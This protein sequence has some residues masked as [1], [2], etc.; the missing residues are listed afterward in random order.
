M[1]GFIMSD[2]IAKL[3]IIACFIAAVYPRNALSQDRVLTLRAALNYS[4]EGNP[5]IRVAWKGLLVQKE[6]IGIATGNLLP[7]VVFEERFMRTDNPT[8]AFMA[9]LNQGRFTAQDFDIPSL[10]NPA[11]ISDFQ[12]A[13][14]IEQP[15]FA[16]KAAI[17]ID[18]AR[19]EFEAKNEE[20]DRKREEV[21]FGVIKGYLGI[22]TAKAY[23]AVAEKGIDDAR[24]H[25]R[26][27]D[28]RYKENLGLYS[29]SLR[30]KAALSSAEERLVTA[31]KN[32]AVA[33]RGL[34]LM[35]GLN[36]SVDV[37]EERPLLELKPLEYYLNLTLSRKDLRSL[38]T[39]YK[40]AENMLKMANA[41]YY[42]T[43]GVGG[44]YQMND[45]AKPFGSEGQ[46]WQVAAFLRWEIF[47]GTKREHERR[48]AAAKIAET[49]E[50]L[51]G[52][53][54]E[55]SFNVYDAYLGVDEAKKGL[56][57]AKTALEAAEEGRR[58]VMA[59]YENS[60]SP[61]VDLLDV[62]TNLDTSRASVIEREGAY[63]AALANL[64]FQSG[65]ILK[66]L[67]ME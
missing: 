49:A 32:L 26:I 59:R 28:S 15:L 50:Y 45:H 56:E 23:V 37:T 24:E 6:E 47:D 46:S 14:S 54:K 52:M 63:L 53:K 9:K 61:L 2:R 33:K 22:Q 55:L 19:K 12:T 48:K 7:K 1:G 18:V 64:G 21:A 3:I 38:E 43:I 42:P 10:N 16:P 13:F 67:G 29:D 41:G 60:L 20:M 66:D 17:G 11:A 35:L 44:S 40:N 65:S 58:L 5:Q 39:R 34:G 57:L 27:A 36:E 62:Q 30:A 4:M 25:L 31:R 8:Y 51:D